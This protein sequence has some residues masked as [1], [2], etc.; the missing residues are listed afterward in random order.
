[1]IAESKR[2]PTYAVG[3]TVFA[4]PKSAKDRWFSINITKVG[5]KYAYGIS[6]EGAE[7]TINI[8]NDM[9]YISGYGHVN[10]IHIQAPFD[11]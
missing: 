6:E 7:I 11:S 3:M 2:I 5:R 8:A 10:E 1:M 4:K 9:R